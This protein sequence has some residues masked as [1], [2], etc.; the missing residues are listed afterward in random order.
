MSAVS[1]LPCTPS[2]LTPSLRRESGY[3]CVGGNSSSIIPDKCVLG[4]SSLSMDFDSYS[5]DLDA[6][7]LFVPHTKYQHSVT[8]GWAGWDMTGRSGGNAINMELGS[9]ALALATC[10]SASPSAPQCCDATFGK[11]IGGLSKSHFLFSLFELT[12]AVVRKLRSRLPV[13]EILHRP[14]FA[15]LCPSDSSNRFCR[16][17]VKRMDLHVRGQ[18]PEAPSSEDVEFVASF[19][20]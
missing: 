4:S 20:V 2:H 7:T 13:V 15:Q 14:C 5:S 6:D 17:L 19:K 12:H 18:C 3:V 9:S 8:L 1:L 11:M 16:Q 10:T